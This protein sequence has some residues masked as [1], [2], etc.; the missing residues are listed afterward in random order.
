VK[1]ILWGLVAFSLTSGLGAFPLPPAL[2]T[3]HLTGKGTVNGELPVAL[4]DQF[5][6]LG[7]SRANALA[8]IE[9]RTVGSR[10]E[11]RLRILDLV[12]DRL[13]EEVALDDWQVDRAHWWSVNEAKVVPV[14][15]RFSII[16]NDWQ[17]GQFPLILDNEYYTVAL[18]TFA[19]STEPVWIDRLELVV[20]STGRGTKTV[21][22]L[23]GYWRWATILGFLPSPFENRVAVILV[24][25]PSG[26]LGKEEPLRFIV[27]GL[28]LKAGF[29]TP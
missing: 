3:G 9:L 25:Q 23:E 5:I 13:L 29:P 15:Q 4:S 20:H 7:W 28:S 16:P 6:A 8:F 2:E 22:T 19:K 12:E 24:V 21:R 27:S 17:L 11:A 1:R 26:W 18:K 10:V 14:L